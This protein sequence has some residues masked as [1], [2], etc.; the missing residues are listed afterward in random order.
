MSK[1]NKNKKKEKNKKALLNS[2][3]GVDRSLYKRVVIWGKSYKA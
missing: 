1:R 2:Y 3:T